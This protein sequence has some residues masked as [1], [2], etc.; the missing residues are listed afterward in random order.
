MTSGVVPLHV[1]VLPK[2][3][4]VFVCDVAVGKEIGNVLVL[5]TVGSVK[6]VGMEFEPFQE[7]IWW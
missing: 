6:L 2:V 5:G 1:G 3:R 4:D 7:L